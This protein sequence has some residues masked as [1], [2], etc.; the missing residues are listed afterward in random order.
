[1]ERHKEGD[2]KQYSVVDMS[3]K[4]T[5]LFQ[6]DDIKECIQKYDELKDDHQSLYIINNDND[7]IVW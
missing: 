4:F 3:G 1:M 5:D 6:S 7:E 2:F